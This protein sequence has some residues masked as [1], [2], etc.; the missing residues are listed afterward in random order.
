[1]SDKITL[2]EEHF[3]KYVCENPSP[4]GLEVAELIDRLVAGFHHIESDLRG[5]VDW[6]NTHHIVVPWPRHFNLAT[7]DSDLLT[8]LVV[9]SHDMMLRV[10]VRPRAHRWQEFIFH[11]RLTRTG[12]LMERMPA[13]E[14]H[15]A[16]IRGQ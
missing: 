9:L 15:I 2:N 16:L 8:R 7:V 14:E 12:S 5:K 10:E 13:I 1:M 3:R 6:S 11:K 4:L